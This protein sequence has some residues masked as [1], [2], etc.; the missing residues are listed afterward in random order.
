MKVP[1]T[2]RAEVERWPLKAPFHITGRTWE[3]IEVVVVTVS[4]GTHI[5][6]GEAAGVYYLKDD[7]SNI[8]RQLE[9]ARPAIEAGMDRPG[10]ERL[11]PAGGARNAVDCALWDLEAQ[12]SGQPV[13]QLAGLSPPTPLVTTYTVGAGPPEQMAA[14]AHAFRDARALKLKLTGEAIDGQRVLAVREAQPEVWLA[15]DANQG[16]D[17]ERLETLM[18]ILLECRVELIEQPFKV[19]QE[20]WLDD[21]GSPIPIAADESVQTSADI[22]S[23]ADRFD[24]INIK[25]DK[26]GGLTEALRMVKL[27]RAQDLEVMVGNMMGTVL[28]TSPAAVIGQLCRIVDLDGPLLLRED[29]TP[30][31]VYRDGAVWCPEAAWGT[32]RQ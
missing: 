13:W 14:T 31:T 7:V 9:A 6:R 5:G 16:F 1:L 2:V 18:P 30:G 4:D 8:I 19:G 29:R 22:E 12:R 27:A 15:I 32:P 17:R 10:L 23:L 25:L 20:A 28:S 3:A 24:V 21:L 11:L 26:C